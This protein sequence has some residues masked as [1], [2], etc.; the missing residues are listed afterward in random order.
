MGEEELVEVV[1]ELLGGLVALAEVLGEGPQDDA[2]EVAGDGRVDARERGDYGDAHLLDGLVVGLALEEAAAAEHLVEE[3][4]GGEDV[5]ATVDGL[6][7]D[8]FRGE[9]AELA[10]DDAG[11]VCS[12]WSAALARPKST[13]F[14]SPCLEMRMLGEIGRAHV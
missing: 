5:G 8:G 4:A 13:S 14:T 1:A 6:A 11:S 10:L 7:L 12:S 3:D 9:V 2:F